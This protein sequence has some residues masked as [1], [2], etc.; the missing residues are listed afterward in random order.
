VGKRI[1]N[2]RAGDR[3]EDL[4]VFLLKTFCAVAPI[5]RQE[6]FGLADA[7]AT[8]LRPDGKFWYAEDSFL[9][10]LK[11]RTEKN[12]ELEGA[13]FQRWLNQEL[14]VFVGRVNLLDNTIELFTLGTALFDRRVHDANG[15]VVWLVDGRDELRDSVLHL[16]L[17]KPILTWSVGDT[18]DADFTDRSYAILKHWLGLERWNRRYFRAGVAREIVW[19]TNKKPEVGQIIHTWTPAL[20]HAA[21]A[22]IEPLVELLGLHCRRHPELWSR[23]HAVE[24]ALRGGGDSDM[25]ASMRDIQR[26]TDTMSRLS[27]IVKEHPTADLVVTIHLLHM[28]AERANFWVYAHGRDGGGSGQR[29][30]GTWEEL[31][32]KGFDHAIEGDIPN[33]KIKLS[34]GRY[35]ADKPI[36]HEFID[37]P[38]ETPTVSQGEHSPCYFLRRVRSTTAD[39][40]RE[41]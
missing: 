15:L 33:A 36:S 28:D 35:F 5:P 7:V 26:M 1:R 32:Q 40:P 24:E 12:V 38:S 25:L 4:G 18:E 10:Q 17:E 23:V 27:D 6:D 9:V 22:D 20:G 11:S 8:L 37:G 16:K 41:K 3:A 14:S 30:E 19:D 39:E 31:K 2:F 21:L 13:V 29:H 34:L